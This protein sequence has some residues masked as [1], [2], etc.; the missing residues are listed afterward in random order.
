MAVRRTIGLA[1]LRVVV[2]VDSRHPPFDL[3][4]AP[5]PK[6]LAVVIVDASLA[7]P[8]G[9]SRPALFRWTCI[10]GLAAV[11]LGALFE[12]GVALP[13]GLACAIFAGALWV[14]L[15]HVLVT[16][17]SLLT[18][19]ALILYALPFIHCVEYVFS[20]ISTFADRDVIWGMQANPYE[21][22][23]R[24]IER[25]ALAGA[26]GA[27]ALVAG[28][29][30]AG[31]LR[32][33]RP[34]VH[35]RKRLRWFSFALLAVIAVALS[36][37]SAPAQTIFQSAY[38][39]SPSP[40]QGT[41]MNAAYLLSYV[42]TSMLA[43]DA[44]L[45]MQDPVRRWKLFVTGVVAALIVFWFQFLRGDR[46]CMGL[47]VAL[48]VLALIG[49]RDLSPPILRWRRVLAVGTVLL[50]VV[51][52]ALIL[53]EVRSTSVVGPAI[54][55]P[56]RPEPPTRPTRPAQPSLVHGPWSGVSLTPLSVI[57]DFERHRMSRRWGSTYID[58]LL[59]LPPGVI[60]AAVGYRRPLE[61]TRGPAWEMRYGQG[62][63]HLMVVPYMNFGAL[64][65]VVILGAWGLLIGGVERA[66]AGGARG[67]L[68]ALTFFVV[69]PL[70]IWYGDMLL[71]RALMCFY[72]TWWLYKALPKQ[73]PQDSLRADLPALAPSPGHRPDDL[74]GSTPP[75]VRN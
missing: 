36:W 1:P 24:I 48:A 72:G 31:I 12:A 2:R 9:T 19:Y 54:V 34:P 23:L 45:E 39:K 10:C 35:E 75:A 38:T 51:G 46:E 74:T 52:V 73:R 40:L 71:V 5:E 26:I 6:S 49:T 20:D 69:C 60:A 50:C 17:Y 68:L 59:S 14:G 21:K 53:G 33:R 37:A 65:I 58:Y 18:R 11:G 22:D 47:V 43:I 8:P 13:I 67:L 30:L 27:L 41:N 15:V 55:Q 56:A 16:R 61:A 32:D 44:L 29:G 42:F 64:G 63:T 4:A 66:A 7:T 70:W 57:G 28:M 3:H 25:M 62:G